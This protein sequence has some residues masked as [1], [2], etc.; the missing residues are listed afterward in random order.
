MTDTREVIEYNTHKSSFFFLKSNLPSCGGTAESQHCFYFIL[1]KKGPMLLF[2]KQTIW[3]I[4][5]TVIILTG[6]V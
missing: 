4:Q 3:K 2:I 1:L 5:T 6:L